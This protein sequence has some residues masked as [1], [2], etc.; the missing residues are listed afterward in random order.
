MPFLRICLNIRKVIARERFDAS[1]ATEFLQYR[2][3]WVQCRPRLAGS[4]VGL[5]CRLEN[6]KVFCR[7]SIVP[8]VTTEKYLQEKRL[9]LNGDIIMSADF[10]G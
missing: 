1:A 2:F 6:E 3:H 9:P 7:R 10:I 8:D 4:S 5:G